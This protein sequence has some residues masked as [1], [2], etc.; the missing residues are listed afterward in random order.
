MP[1][2][3]SQLAA[4]QPVGI[5]VG[6][7]LDLEGAEGES[8]FA[9]RELAELLALRTGLP[10]ELVDERLTTVRAHRSIREQQGST[11]GRR[12][13]VDA[14][15]ASILLHGSSMRREGPRE[16]TAPAGLIWLAAWPISPAGQPMERIT[17]P[18]AS[19]S[20]DSLESHASKSPLVP[21]ADPAAAGALL[22]AGIYDSLRNQGFGCHHR[23]R[24]GGCHDTSHRSGPHSRLPS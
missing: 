5:V 4:A 7:P 15:A 3:L 1:G 16:G 23:F 17:I 11:R 9:A 10:I 18:G 22:A 2:F 24:A 8:A 21:A 20:A 19:R 13:D 12:E 14:L 6:H